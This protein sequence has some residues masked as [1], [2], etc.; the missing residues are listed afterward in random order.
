M[1]REYKL[2]DALGKPTGPKRVVDWANVL[3]FAPNPALDDFAPAQCIAGGSWVVRSH[4]FFVKQVW[5]DHNH[6]L[7]RSIEGSWQ[8][9]AKKCEAW[10]IDYN[11]PLAPCAMWTWRNGILDSRF[12]LSR[13]PPRSLAPSLPRSLPPSL[14]PSLPPRSTTCHA[15]FCPAAHTRHVRLARRDVAPGATKVL[16][17]GARCRGGEN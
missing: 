16:V 2:T 6:T 10:T 15:L 1:G 8:D 17:G 12:S 7:S 5:D 9:C 4:M 11:E 13:S 14:A 3:R